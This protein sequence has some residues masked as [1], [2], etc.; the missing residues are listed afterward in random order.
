MFFILIL[1]LSYNM[2]II[3][4]SIKKYDRTEQYTM[5]LKAK[6]RKEVRNSS[7]HVM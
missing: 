4:N 7:K 3:Y 2:L 6:E 1:I 5:K